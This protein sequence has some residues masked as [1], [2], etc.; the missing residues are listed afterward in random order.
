MRPRA[1]GKPRGI[2][3]AAFRSD[4]HRIRRFLPAPAGPQVAG[5]DLA[6]PDGD[7]PEGRASRSDPMRER[8]NSGQG[9]R[10]GRVATRRRIRAD[11]EERGVNQTLSLSMAARLA[12]LLK[13]ASSRTYGAVLDAAAAAVGVAREDQSF[14][15]DRAGDVAEIQRL[16]LGFTD[17]LRK[18][19]EGLRILSAFVLRMRTRAGLDGDGVLH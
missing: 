18:L 8:F 3:E 4:L 16:M 12:P 19:E 14:A 9:A 13:A 2:R 15:P 10:S 5:T 6:K 17:E 11:L 7:G 1:P